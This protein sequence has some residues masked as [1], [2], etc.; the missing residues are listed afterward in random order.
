M[1]RRHDTSEHVFVRQTPQC[2]SGVE[3][4]ASSGKMKPPRVYQLDFAYRLSRIYRNCHVASS[5]Y[6]VDSRP[7]SWVKTGQVRTPRKIAL[8]L[9]DYERPYTLVG[10]GY[11]P[12][13]D[14]EH[15]CQ[16]FGSNLLP[17]HLVVDKKSEIC[18]PDVTSV[19]VIILL[20]ENQL[21]QWR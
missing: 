17:Y 12:I 6:V 4:A 3:G 2:I 11:S 16:S 13:S 14:I 20:R 1:F 19:A 10:I 15:S 7:A 21:V 8:N 18:A 9:G 5:A